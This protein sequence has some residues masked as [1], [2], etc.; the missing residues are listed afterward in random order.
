[1][2]GPA[3]PLAAYD[4]DPGAQ[5]FR[6][7]IACHTLNAD[8]GPRAGPTLAGIFGRRIATLPG[9]DFSPALKKLDIVWTPETLSK[10]FEVGPGG[11]HARHQDAGA[12]RR[13]RG[14]GGSRQVPGEG[15][16]ALI[17]SAFVLHLFLG[18]LALAQIVL[19]RAHR[20]ARRRA[21]GIEILLGDHGDAAVVAH[22][23]DVE[24]AW[25]C[26]CTSSACLRASLPRARSCSSRRTACRSGC[27]RT[28]APP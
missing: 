6:A 18:F 13:R 24:A 12:A 1:M 19:G 17:A 4:G 5:V 10:L 16:A 20:R 9:Y 3:D 15:D 2:N 28:A 7:C 23:D 11:L 25:A 8:E 26:P 22:L 27:S 14:P 21:V